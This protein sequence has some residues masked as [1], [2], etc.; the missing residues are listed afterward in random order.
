VF[1]ALMNAA[2]CGIEP[3]GITG[4]LVPYDTSVKD[5][6]GNWNKI[7]ICNFIPDYKG[8]IQVAYQ[9]GDIANISA[10][11]VYQGEVDAGQFSI[12]YGM[13]KKIVHKPMMFGKRGAM[14]GVYA[15]FRMKNGSGGFVFLNED[16]INRIKAS[17][18]NASGANSPWVKHTEAM[19]MKSAVK[20]LFKWMPW[21]P[22]RADRINAAIHSDNASE[23]G[24]TGRD[25]AASLDVMDAAMRL[26]AEQPPTVDKSTRLAET[27]ATGSAD[28][29]NAASFSVGSD[30][31]SPEPEAA[32]K[33][34]AG[35]VEK[36]RNEIIT[37][38]PGALT[39]KQVEK[40]IA[41][42]LDSSGLP[43][44]DLVWEAV[45]KAVKA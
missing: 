5:A 40:I 36:L 14:V 42:N 21:S 43:D 30:N 9:C 8:L 23:M 24:W 20:Q 22:E 18:Q 27:L 41:A 11:P 33:G 7:K 32:P 28:P 44:V 3:N 45:A 1:I 29:A 25:A 10:H 6:Q 37:K 34:A 39:V 17:A 31:D 12:E 16:D 38:H 26:E 35:A 15:S 19:W 13:E 4:H 2:A